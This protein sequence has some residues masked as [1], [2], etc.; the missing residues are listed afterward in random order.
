M[1]RVWSYCQHNTF[2]PPHLWVLPGRVAHV[3]EQAAGQSSWGWK[4]QY[5]GAQVVPIRWWPLS[6]GRGERRTQVRRSLFAVQVAQTSVNE[7]DLWI[8]ETYSLNKQT[9]HQLWENWFQKPVEQQLTKGIRRA[10]PLH[11]AASIQFLPCYPHPSCGLSE[12]KCACLE[13]NA[14]LCCWLCLPQLMECRQLWLF[15]TSVLPLGLPVS[16]SSQFW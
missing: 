12:T 10:A 11:F 3:M 5:L 7:I 9:L 6:P 13:V 1:S 16:N 4:K 15:A 14:L 8:L 2:T